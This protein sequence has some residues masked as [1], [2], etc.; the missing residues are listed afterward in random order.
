MNP[1][2]RKPSARGAPG[3]GAS[4]L[5]RRP[6]D[7]LLLGEDEDAQ[8]AALLDARGPPVAPDLR[9]RREPH[10]RHL[11]E[12]HL[13]VMLG[14]VARHGLWL[15]ARFAPAEHQAPFANFSRT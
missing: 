3:K 2:R 4:A 11:R 13:V 1:P 14:V 8:G 6:G 9:R 7:D 12:R 5:A 10:P 15:A